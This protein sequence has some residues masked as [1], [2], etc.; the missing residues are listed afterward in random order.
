MWS[1]VILLEPDGGHFDAGFLQGWNEIVF[2]DA[3]INGL[4]DILSSEELS[5][6]SFLGDSHPPSISLSARISAQT[7]KDFRT[8]NSIVL[9]VDISVTPEMCFV[10][11][12]P[13]LKK[14]WFFGHFSRI[15]SQN[16]A[17]REK[18]FG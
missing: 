17:R 15:H 6:E 9:A 8:T 3:S 1:S 7:H 10:A 13:V 4:I 16:C 5:V 2:N 11:E 12:E 14:I 18:S